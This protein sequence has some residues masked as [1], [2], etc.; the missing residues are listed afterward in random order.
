ML[1]DILMLPRQPQELTRNR[2]NLDVGD[3]IAL[4]HVMHHYLQKELLQL[5]SLEEPV[6]TYNGLETT[7]QEDSFD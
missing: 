4:D 1:S 5:Q 7:T 3:Q 6:L 2:H